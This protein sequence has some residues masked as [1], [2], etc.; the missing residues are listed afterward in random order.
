MSIKAEGVTTPS[1][2]LLTTATA[3][4]VRTFS[5]TVDSNPFFPSP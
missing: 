5:P 4:V 3:L 1:P 2:V